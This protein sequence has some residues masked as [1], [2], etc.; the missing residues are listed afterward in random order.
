[1]GLGKA[2]IIPA[3]KKPKLTG[4]VENVCNGK[5]QNCEICKGQRCGFVFSLSNP[6]GTTLDDPDPGDRT[7]FLDYA[8]AAMKRLSRLTN[9]DILVLTSKVAAAKYPE[10]YSALQ[11]LSPTI[12][13]VPADTDF[14]DNLDIKQ[15]R[16][17][18]VHTYLSLQIFNPKYFGEYHVLAFMDVDVFPMRSVDEV[19]CSNGKFAAVVRESSGSDYRK[20]GFNS[21]FY[22]YRSDPKDFDGLMAAFRHHVSQPAVSLGIQGVLNSYFRAAGSFFCLSPTYNCVGITGPPVTPRVQST[23]CSF[24]K[25]SELFSLSKG[26]VHAKL[27]MLK[28]R[29]WLPVVTELWAKHLAPDALSRLPP[30]YLGDYVPAELQPSIQSCSDLPINAK[31][32]SGPNKEFAKQVRGRLLQSLRSALAKLEAEG[33]THVVFAG[34]QQFVG[35]LKAEDVFKDKSVSLSH[36]P[37]CDAASQRVLMGKPGGGKVAVTQLRCLETESPDS[38]FNGPPL[39]D[40]RPKSI[41]LVLE[42]SALPPGFLHSLGA[43]LKWRANI[44]AV[45]CVYNSAFRKSLAASNSP[46]ATL[47]STANWM[48]GLGFNSNLAGTVSLLPLDKK[49]WKGDYEVCGP[50]YSGSQSCESVFI[51]TR[52]TDI[53]KIFEV[54]YNTALRPS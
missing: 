54:R 32:F 53:D 9:K 22:V 39:E 3:P 51:S 37:L 27:S 18:H 43:V 1:M 7:T 44:V 45:I 5:V 8:Y 48:S 46:V 40:G 2:P 30:G 29:K 26:I 24:S 10:A 42:L 14:Y 4:E 11:K 19:F 47:K 21:G 20:S 12:K 50:A 33:Q 52:A 15:L 23:K 41:I 35:N 6:Y 36:L 25:E 34:T 17:K 38:A 13:I 16:P 49:C 31:Q 28:Y